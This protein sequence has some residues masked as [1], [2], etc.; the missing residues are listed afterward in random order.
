MADLPANSSN[1]WVIACTTTSDKTLCKAPPP[2]ITCDELKADWRENV[3]CSRH[4]LKLS[5]RR[6]AFQPAF[7]GALAWH[8]Y[9]LDVETVAALARHNRV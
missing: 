1:L 5:L 2:A 9:G 7:A 4:R 6:A 3:H 8:L